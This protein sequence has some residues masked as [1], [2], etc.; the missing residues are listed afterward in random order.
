M[1]KVNYRFNPESLSF[2]KIGT[3][4]KI[5]ILKAFTYFTAS[6]VIFFFYL[7]IFQHYFDSPKEKAL[8]RLNQQK[9][10]QFEIMQKKLDQM[11]KVLDDMQERD[12]NIYRTIFEAEP[13]SKTVREAGFGGVNRYEELE[14]ATNSELIVNTA[15]SLDI[16]SKRLYIQSKSYD[17]VI[18]K[19]LNK[20]HLLACLPAIQ[21]ISNKN[22]T[23]AA[24]G[25]GW[26]IHPIYKIRKFHEGMDFSSPP[27]TNI[28]ATAD[29]IVA[30][31]E[32][33]PDRGFGNM[34]TL[35]HGFGYR[36][37]YAHMEGFNVKLGQK[38]KR[39]DI[40]GYV[41]STGLS[42]APHLHYE[43]H[44][45]GRPVNPINFYFNDLTPSE[46]DQ[47]IDISSRGAQTFY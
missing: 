43:V 17:E 40:I 25:Y 44:K 6:I 13:I 9:D 47:I 34:V 38:V 29:G 31:M 10:L 42:T 2:D 37:L 26:R 7:I 27:G 14:S 20:E 15:K 24:S 11:S 16:I 22:L 5:W 8:I 32:R 4:F 45:N 3:S 46:F 28:Y 18:E 36:T 39:G 21:P 41:G 19:A 23:R 33:N 1:A 30:V 35:D 12:D